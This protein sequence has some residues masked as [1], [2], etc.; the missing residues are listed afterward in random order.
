M[1]NEL[2]IFLK[3]LRLLLHDYAACANPSARNEILKDIRLLIQCL[4]QLAETAERKAS[5]SA[6]QI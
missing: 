5:D 2:E 6:M 4:D 1:R 3:E